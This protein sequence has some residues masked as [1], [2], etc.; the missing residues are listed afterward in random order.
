M[1]SFDSFSPPPAENTAFSWMYK[2]KKKEI[3]SPG[4]VFTSTANMQSD[5]T[6]SAIR[7]ALSEKIKRDTPKKENFSGFSKVEPLKL[8]PI[9]PLNEP[10]A[11]LNRWFHQLWDPIQEAKDS[12]TWAVPKTVMAS[13]GSAVSIIPSMIT[14]TMGFEK[15]PSLIEAADQYSASHGWSKAAQWGLWTP[16]LLAD[17][18]LGGPTDPLRLITFGA[19]PLAKTAE[20]IIH[21][22]PALSGIVN[23]GKQK[24]LTRSVRRAQT[25]NEESVREIAVPEII[26]RSFKVAQWPETAAVSEL[27][28]I[29]KTFGD[30]DILEHVFGSKKS[31]KITANNPSGSL[32][33]SYVGML[34]KHRKRSLDDLTNTN[35]KID[36]EIIRD[37]K[38]S[39]YEKIDHVAAYAAYAEKEIL[40]GV[41]KTRIHVPFWAPAQ[42]AKKF[43]RGIPI[44]P[45]PFH[46]LQR[47]FTSLF[48]SW[49]DNP[50]FRKPIKEYLPKETIDKINNFAL[51]LGGDDIQRRLYMSEGTD[52]GELTASELEQF[53]RYVQ[54]GTAEQGMDTVLV[55]EKDIFA[56]VE[57]ELKAMPQQYRLTH[58]KNLTATVEALSEVVKKFPTNLF[59]TS[60]VP[61]NNAT[62]YLKTLVENAEKNATGKIY[63]I[64]YNTKDFNNHKFHLDFLMEKATR[65]KEEIKNL[66]L[67]KEQELKG[68]SESG[69]AETIPEFLSSAI[70]A[71]GGAFLGKKDGVTRYENRLAE[72]FTDLL[73]MHRQLRDATTTYSISVKNRDFTRNV[74]KTLEDI[75]NSWFI[76]DETIKKHFEHLNSPEGGGSDVL[77]ALSSMLRDGEAR[78]FLKQV[79]E[80]PLG[81]RVSPKNIDDLLSP[82]SE[83]VT[84]ASF[85]TKEGIKKWMDA[86]R[87]LDDLAIE[88]LEIQD[89]FFKGIES[90]VE[91]GKM[92]YP[93]GERLKEY[94]K[95]LGNESFANVLY[96]MRDIADARI[97]GS[98][99]KSL[100]DRLLEPMQ[101]AIESANVLLRT[102]FDVQYKQITESFAKFQ[103]IRDHKKLFDFYF[104]PGGWMDQLDDLGEKV[105]RK[106][107]L[108][109]H[110]IEAMKEVER[111]RTSIDPAS[112]DYAIMFS[113]ENILKQ[114]TLLD[115]SLEN[116]VGGALE[117]NLVMAVGK[118]VQYAHTL[119]QMAV[120][121]GNQW[122]SARVYEISKK[123]IEEGIAELSKIFGNKQKAQAYAENIRE[124]LK[125]EMRAQRQIEARMGMVGIER[126]GYLPYVLKGSK[127]EIQ[128]L[129]DEI[130]AAEGIAKIKK[131]DKKAIKKVFGGGNYRFGAEEHRLFRDAAGV[132]EFIEQTNYKRVHREGLKALEVEVDDDII[133]AIG[134]RKKKQLRAFSNRDMIGKLQTYLPGNTL[135]RHF[136]EKDRQAVEFATKWQSLEKIVP[137]MKDYYVSN[138]LYSYLKQYIPDGKADSAIYKLLSKYWSLSTKFQVQFSLVHLKNLAGLAFI[139]GV[140]PGKFSKIIYQAI[141]DSKNFEKLYPGAMNYMT[142]IAKALEHSDLYKS[143]TRSGIS[144]F[145]GAEQ[146]TSVAENIKKARKPQWSPS[147]IMDKGFASTMIFDVMDRGAKMALYE[148]LLEQGVQPNMAADW[149]NYFLIDYSAKNLNPEARKWGYAVAPFF[150]WKIQNMLLHVPNMIENPARYAMVNY[151]RHYVPDKVFHSNPYANSKMPDAI[152][153]TMAMPLQDTEGNQLYLSMDMPWDQYVNLF[154]R[155]ILTNP[156]DPVAWR[157]DIWRFIA[158]RTRMGQSLREAFNPFDYKR[159]RNESL[160]ESFF[161]D[162]THDG[163]IDETFW[164]T[165][166]LV[167]KGM[168]FA[169]ALL[170]PMAWKNLGP[171]AL[172]FA[173]QSTIGELKPVD[174]YGKLIREKNT[175]WHNLFGIQGR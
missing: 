123:K 174:P 68:I 152:A 104:R 1:E 135:I 101:G 76:M 148:E 89:R 119:E 16:A 108:N 65:V 22:G 110:A 151:F 113:K 46:G 59:A 145:R 54:H 60:S 3:D 143:A 85:K 69:G 109:Y 159:I 105:F 141:K 44:A 7:T 79:A 13:L 93:Q 111:I 20:K 9:N 83:G 149:V 173:V 86:S 139:A 140:N 18:A 84:I 136:S 121:P 56:W 126:E 95:S 112:E 61:L 150:A 50:E 43:R 120:D 67:L 39:L 169:Y 35:S 175:F 117:N 127:E 80:E 51:A 154:N 130:T 48:Y 33:D 42:I 15:A 88:R 87:P 19:R 99:E 129:R 122:R 137:S 172:D 71:K 31:T 90:H 41:P 171:T 146:F 14:T 142:R 74:S 81:P 12:E 103:T 8:D 168:S 134:D 29:Q 5:M 53:I 106:V 164:G 161:G 27:P 118:Y 107:G 91:N 78:L 158:Q 124:I 157:G 47:G 32:D 28:Q 37:P 11:W 166:P 24:A 75:N 70:E 125:V 77:K 155:T 63:D 147:R 115:P 72:K 38:T 4:K 21:E 131:S 116:K 128:Q 114:A 97:H 96:A 153:S 57:K 30:Y 40:D 36:F 66:M 144:H 133:A 163:L 10:G 6:F 62:S 49:V 92:S 94:L 64:V 45:S 82:T 165:L 160:F 138:E 73:S 2:D 100:F 98:L 26:A 102:E 17:I 58:L 52:I 25:L 156:T 34:E 23:P 167:K 132:Q 162:A 55:H 170:N